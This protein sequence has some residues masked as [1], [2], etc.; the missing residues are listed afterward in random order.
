MFTAA[1]LFDLAQTEHAAI[2]EGCHYAWEALKKIEPYLAQVSRQSPPKRFPGASISDR[3][4]I[5]EGTVVEPGVLIKGPAIIGRNCHLR[6]NAYLRENVI[7]GDN[8]VVGNASELKQFPSVQWRAG[9]ALQLHRRFHP[10][11]QGAPGRGRED[12]QHQAA[13]R[14][15]HGGGGRAGPH[16]LGCTSLARWW[17][18]ARRRGAT[19]C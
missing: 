9:A 17:A 10:R 15:R 4:L 1:D 3:V 12:F 16:L 6:H 2:F 13:A 19:R 5:G 11:S 18:T 7:I 8:C 14:Q